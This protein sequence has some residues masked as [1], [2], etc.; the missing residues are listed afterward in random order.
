M[1]RLI[2]LK[3]KCNYDKFICKVNVSNP[4]KSLQIIMLNLTM[5]VR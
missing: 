1:K 4:P 5:R 3:Y 2:R